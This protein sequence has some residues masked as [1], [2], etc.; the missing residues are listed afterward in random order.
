MPFFNLVYQTYSK[1]HKEILLIGGALYAALFIAIYS[2]YLQIDGES[3]LIKRYGWII[4]IL[5]YLT[6]NLLH[7]FQTG[8]YLVGAQAPKLPRYISLE[9]ETPAP[10]VVHRKLAPEPQ[11][12]PAPVETPIEPVQ[13]PELPD[14]SGSE[15]DDEISAD[16]YFPT[17]SETP[18]IVDDYVKI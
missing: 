10:A 3:G 2:D 12:V 4:V 18:I 7:H 1:N 8:T 5:D 9:E 13:K 11:V 15:S 16:D 6:L 17:T 14:E